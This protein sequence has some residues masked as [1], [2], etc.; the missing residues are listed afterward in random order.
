MQSK[1]NLRLLD[2]QTTG[3]MGR[4]SEIN[5]TPDL[6]QTTTIVVLPLTVRKLGLI[7]PMW[8]IGLIL[9]SMMVRLD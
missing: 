4:I 2:L 9:Q 7:R 6:T 3:R 5:S 1:A 8:G